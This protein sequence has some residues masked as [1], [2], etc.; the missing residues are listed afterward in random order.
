ME[1]ALH[2][3]WLGGF[4][5]LPPVVAANSSFSLSSPS[6]HINDYSSQ[7]LCPSNILT[8]TKQSLSPS[9]ITAHTNQSM[10]TSHILSNNKQS[11]SSSNNTSD[12]KQS[13][14]L[15]DI[16][17]DSSDATPA[18]TENDDAN[19]ISTRTKNT[20]P[21]NDIPTETKKSTLSA[22]D[23]CD[24]TLIS[25]DIPT[26]T[27][28]PHNQPSANDL[29]VTETDV[30]VSERKSLDCNIIGRAANYSANNE[31]T[32]ESSSDITEC[33]S[34]VERSNIDSILVASQHESVDSEENI[35]SLCTSKA[36]IS[37]I[38]SSEN[39]K[40]DDSTRWSKENDVCNQHSSATDSAFSEQSSST[41]IDHS[42]SMDQSSTMSSKSSEEDTSSPMS[43]GG[44][45]HS[46]SLSPTSPAHARVSPAKGSPSKTKPKLPPKP[47]TLSSL[48]KT[49][50]SKPPVAKK[51]NLSDHKPV[52]PRKP[53]NISRSRTPEQFKNRTSPSSSKNRVSPS[54]SRTRT[55]PSPNRTAASPSRTRSSP[56]PSR[57]RISPSSPRT[58]TPASP[59]EDHSRTKNSPSPSRRFDF[60]RKSSESPP[61]SRRTRHSPVA[62]GSPGVS[63]ARSP[64]SLTTTSPTDTARLSRRS[65]ASPTRHL[66]KRFDDSPSRIRGKSRL[67]EPGFSS[68]SLRNAS[69]SPTRSPRTLC[70]ATSPSPTRTSRT[71][72]SRNVDALH[73][74]SPTNQRAANL[75]KDSR[76]NDTR[77]TLAPV[78][79]KRNITSS[80][81]VKNTSSNIRVSRTFDSPSNSPRSTGSPRNLGTATNTSTPL[82]SQSVGSS[83]KTPSHSPPLFQPAP[84]KCNTLDYYSNDDDVSSRGQPSECDARAQA[85][86]GDV[87]AR[88]QPTR[89]DVTIRGQPMRATAGRDVTARVQKLVRPQPMRSS[90]DRDVRGASTSRNAKPQPPSRD[91]KPLHTSPRS[92]D[93]VLKSRSFDDS[94]KKP[95]PKPRPAHLSLK[96][97]VENFQCPPVTSCFAV[98]SSSSLSSPENS[99]RNS[100]SSSQSSG[101]LPSRTCLSPCSTS[102]SCSDFTYSKPGQ[103]GSVLHAADGPAS[104]SLKLQREREN[105]RNMKPWYDASDPSAAP[106]SP[107]AFSLKL[108]RDKENDRNAINSPTDA[109]KSLMWRSD[110]S[111]NSAASQE[112]LAMEVDPYSSLEGET[113]RESEADVLE[114]QCEDDAAQGEVS[115]C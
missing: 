22:N 105:D 104:F 64:G 41:D 74:G 4:S 83:R 6:C 76:D 8:H 49:P 63:P 15:C 13:L 102:S 114:M 95:S 108:Q 97:N 25:S 81:Q 69:P 44:R 101:S 88:Y 55:S 20:L 53:E 77:I 107:A 71:L 38:L 56:S 7:S 112:N 99:T 94:P 58:R 70:S 42:S 40:M 91:R 18:S 85:T 1:A 115:H 68:P 66:S 73:N 36:V 103:D 50:I 9:N 67:D 37:L 24:D 32:I 28:L 29:S 23:D 54:S 14:S 75:L 35:P 10:S 110:A 60:A 47:E 2:H 12:T 72:F 26:K 82:S 45:G 48:K 98:F 5:T 21:L 106:S 30:N 39:D 19:D 43:V 113:Y 78:P 96:S 111:V 34:V 52:P 11:L 31:D 86:R 80:I 61:V 59:S 87:T 84:K 65:Q 3:P 17:T 93:V 79:V 57:T 27:I 100:F 46:Y 51:P 33:T 89:H 109:Q 90:T 62:A 16:P 92:C